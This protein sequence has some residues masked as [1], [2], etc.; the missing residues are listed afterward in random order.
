MSQ[1]IEPFEIHF[2]DSAIEDLRD[3]L[4]RTRFP[5][6]IE[7]VEWDYGTELEYL[8]QLVEYWR[9]KFDW[10]AREAELNRFEHFRTTIDGLM[11][12]PTK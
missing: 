6:Q 5:D 7:G 12:N 8:K 2:D 3:R 4:A 11:R 9:D 10:R 1:D